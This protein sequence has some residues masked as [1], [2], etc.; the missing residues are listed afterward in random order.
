MNSIHGNNALNLFPDENSEYQEIVIVDVHWITVREAFPLL[1]VTTTQGVWSIIT[2]AERKHG[3][4]VERWNIGTDDKPRYLL[5]KA[6]VENVAK[7]MGK[8]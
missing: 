8:L 7:A 2:R 4:K 1:K 5:N 3:V 6:D